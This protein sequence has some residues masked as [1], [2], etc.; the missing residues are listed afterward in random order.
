MKLSLGKKRKI[1]Q[2]WISIEKRQQCGVN[3]GAIVDCDCRLPHHHP[4]TVGETL[5]SWGL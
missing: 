2:E 5:S 4:R 1:I 3:W